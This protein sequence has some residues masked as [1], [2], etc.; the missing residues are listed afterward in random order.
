MLQM[1]EEFSHLGPESR[2]MEMD[3]SGIWCAAIT[4]RG[5]VCFGVIVIEVPQ[6]QLAHLSWFIKL[7]DEG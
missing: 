6:G 1:G 4:E 7:P 5:S 2:G 3:V